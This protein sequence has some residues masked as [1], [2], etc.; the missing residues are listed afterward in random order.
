M[1]QA[2]ASYLLLATALTTQ[3]TPPTLPDSDTGQTDTRQLIQYLLDQDLGTRKFAF[4]DVVRASSGKKV[5]AVDQKNPSHQELIEAVSTAVEA[6]I[7][8]FNQPNSPI[9]QLRRI[10]EASRYF[11]DQLR[12]TINLS[13]RLSCQIPRNNQGKQQ[14]SGYPD[15]LIIH[16][17]EDGTSTHAYLDPKLFEASARASSLRTFYF[18]PRSRTQKIQHDAIHLLIGISHDGQQ[19][20]WTFSDWELCDLSKFQVRL[21]TEFQA[22]NRD[23]YRKGLIIRSSKK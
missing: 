9:R 4:P 21:K 5:I 16:T 7:Q 20:A 10:N 15:L 6:T 3:A 18:E 13:P 17:S 22:S 1:K 12:H 19:G 2:L 11:E 14:R 8:L 23:I